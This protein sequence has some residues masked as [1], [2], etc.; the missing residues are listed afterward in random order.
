MRLCLGKLNKSYLAIAT[1]DNN[2]VTF[3]K[4]EAGMCILTESAKHAWVQMQSD[5][6]RHSKSKWTGLTGMTNLLCICTQT[7]GMERT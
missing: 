4:S 7:R 6:I 2:K 5:A 3:L 1:L